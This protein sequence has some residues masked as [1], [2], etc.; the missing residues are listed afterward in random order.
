ML[1]INT[2]NRHT[3]DTVMM[4]LGAISFMG[5]YLFGFYVVP[6]MEKQKKLKK[7]QQE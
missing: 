2:E 7:E 6:K 4:L 1:I 5:G 3:R